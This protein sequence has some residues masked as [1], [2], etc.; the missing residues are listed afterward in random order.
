VLRFEVE[1][2]TYALF[3]EAMT[4]LRRQT[5]STLDDDSAL[6][7]MARHVLGG[8]GDAGRASYQIALSVCTHC[9]SAAQQ[10]GGRLVAVGADVIEQAHCDGQHLGYIATTAANENA[11]V[12]RHAQIG[13][14]DHTHD[15][16]AHV[17]VGAESHSHDAQAR[18]RAAVNHVRPAPRSKQ[19]IPP[20]L[21][22]AALRRDHERCRVP[23][24]SH[25]TFLDL[26]H[27][28]P[29]SEGG[30]HELENLITICGA[31]HRAAHLGKVLITGSATKPHF[32]HAGGSEYGQPETPHA[33]EAHTKVF[34]ALRHLGFR[35]SDVQ[36]V[37][38]QLRERNDLRE[39]GAE[40]LLREALQKLAPP[41][42]KPIRS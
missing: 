9:G 16:D 10:A 7:L 39:A 29:R 23:G 22:R 33:I 40:R 38:Q 24:C 20:A 42:A 8:P 3:R 21:R 25:A 30:Q 2:E 31:H 14:E 4:Q 1:P 35:E 28:V 5:G 27:I 37:L 11:A 13:A 34:S 32:R 6:L 36:V 17:G 41:R 12:E 18:L 26:H 19:T 15:G